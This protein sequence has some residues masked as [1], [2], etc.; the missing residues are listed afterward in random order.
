M[1]FQQH[2]AETHSRPFNMISYGTRSHLRIFT[3]CAF[4]KG[5]GTFLNAKYFNGD[6]AEKQVVC[7]C[8]IFYMVFDAF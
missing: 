7:F 2:F 4:W 1:C 8:C 6:A 3:R 5:S